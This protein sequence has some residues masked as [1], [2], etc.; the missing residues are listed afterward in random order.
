[1]MLFDYSGYDTHAD[2]FDD[3][4]NYSDAGEDASDDD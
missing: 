4:D 1:M 3:D 2:A